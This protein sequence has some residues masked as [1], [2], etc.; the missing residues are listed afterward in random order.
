MISGKWKGDRRF[1]CHN[2]PWRIRAHFFRRFN[3]H[4]CQG[5]G[6]SFGRDS[7]N[8]RHTCSERCG[9]EIGRR[10][11]FPFALIIDRGIGFQF[12]SRRTMA[13][14]TVQLARVRNGNLDQNSIS[15]ALRQGYGPNRQ[16]AR[17][18]T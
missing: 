6:V 11:R 10:K 12:G 16:P 14:Q 1:Q 9:H 3:G 2:S 7:H 13:G 17:G 18:G 8:R 15:P 4:S 5:D